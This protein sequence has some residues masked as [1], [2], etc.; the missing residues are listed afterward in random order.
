MYNRK[1]TFII[2]QS[3]VENQHEIH[4]N[5]QFSEIGE[6]HLYAFVLSKTSFLIHGIFTSRTVSNAHTTNA[7]CTCSFN[8]MCELNVFALPPITRILCMVPVTISSSSV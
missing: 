1:L 5:C 2:A 7:K 3:V 6:N 4:A 8:A